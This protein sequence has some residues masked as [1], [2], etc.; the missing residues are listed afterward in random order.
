[1]Y[2]S[3]SGCARFSHS[4]P[5]GPLT[6]VEQVRQ[7]TPEAVAAQAPVRLRGTV[8]YV[9]G[10]FQLLLVQDATGA[11]RVGSLPLGIDRGTVVELQGTV[12]SGGSTPEVVSE[13]IRIGDRHSPLPEPARPDAQDLASGRLQYRYVEIEGVV[14][15]AFLDR[16][17]RYSLVVH[18]LGWDVH[19]GIRNQSA[20]DYRSLV[21]AVVRARGDLVTSLDAR[22]AAV[23]VKLWVT[24]LEDVVV[25]RPS[26]SAADLPVTT[27]RSVVSMD[28]GRPSDHRIRLHGRV[29]LEAG[30]LSFRDSTGALPLQP[31]PAESIEAGSA[32]DVLCFVGQ[33][34]GELALTGCSVRERAL[35]DRSPVPLPVL[36][37]VNQVKQ[38]SEDEARRAYPVHLRAVVTYHNPVTTNTFLQDRTGG[39]YVFFD[40]QAQPALNAGDVAELEGFSGPGQFAPVVRGTSVHVVGR[41]ALPEPLR[42]DMEQVF[43]GIADSEWVEANGI[44]HSIRRQAG[45]SSLGITW[46]MHHFSAYV[47]GD[48]AL[49]ASLLDSHVRLLG[50][51]GTRFNFKRQILG[52]QLF[53]PD[54]RFI[55]VEGGAPHAPPLL[56]VDQLLQ[57]SSASNFGERS[58]VRGVVILTQPT[59]PTYVSDATGGVLIQ[60]HP[61]AALKVGDWVEV[62][63]LPVSVNGLFNP[64][65]RDAEIRELG[66][67]VPP[68]PVLVT[69]SDILE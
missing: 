56:N 18:A 62:T 9:D 15:S 25:V 52:V 42:V 39:I 23:G 53:V 22:G 6:T 40:G 68:D 31:A 50:V 60:D 7:L 51:C 8:T 30:R 32:L 13:S 47:S 66:Q 19:V 65:L 41:Q 57:F 48:T 26:P 69:A 12:A 38:L 46:G 34:H 61:A 64:V 55:R 37:T 35:E 27:V 2:L 59:G 63:G 4:A 21:D 44:V 11:V 3:A 1:M 67:A 29:S 14:R 58:R 33:Q 5:N 28:P 54:V 36:T 43:A 45:Y 17:G 49:P 20:F 10:A 24:S 16:A